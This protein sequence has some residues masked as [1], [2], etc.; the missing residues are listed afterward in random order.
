M[1]SKIDSGWFAGERLKIQHKVTKTSAM[2]R[3]N[4]AITAIARAGFLSRDGVQL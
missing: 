4:K 1:E 2:M 3:R